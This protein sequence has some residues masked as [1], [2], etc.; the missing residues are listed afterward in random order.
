MQQSKFGTALALA[1]AVMATLAL[2]VRVHLTAT[3]DATSYGAAL[4]EIGRFFTIL[5]NALVAV[6]LIAH[7]ARRP[8]SASRLAGMTLSICIVGVVYHLLLARF[9]DLSGL[10]V[11]VDFALHTAVP[12]LTFAWWVL[13][14]PK[15]PLGVTAPLTWLI[16]PAIYAV[17][18]VARGMVDGTYPYFFVNLDEL[19]WGGLIISLLQFLAA[20]AVAG[21]LLWGL[22]KLLAKLQSA[23]PG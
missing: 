11:P 2:I 3:E 16:W 23:K 7:V 10:E 5:T 18:A 9:A 14:A 15:A 22:G 6:L 8:Q 12:A 17:Y 1:I 4:W 21:Y 20:F 19:G 13:F